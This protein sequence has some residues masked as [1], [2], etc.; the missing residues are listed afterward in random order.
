MRTYIT[1]VG[2]PKAVT[3]SIIE[4]LKKARLPYFQLIIDNCLD[5]NIYTNRANRRF[6]GIGG[7]EGLLNN[8]KLR[9]TLNAVKSQGYNPELEVEKV[10]LPDEIIYKVFMKQYV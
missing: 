6:E 9:K 4:I 3:K 8:K 1:F 7:I 5:V 2:C 10:E